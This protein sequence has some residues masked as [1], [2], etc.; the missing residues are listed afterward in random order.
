[1]SLD[2]TKTIQSVTYNG[3]PWPV[4]GGEITPI[5]G[6]FIDNGTYYAPSGKAYSQVVVSIP[7][8]DG[9]VV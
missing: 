2:N 9:S 4:A 7:V 1:M 6:T 5:S 3:N 8:Y